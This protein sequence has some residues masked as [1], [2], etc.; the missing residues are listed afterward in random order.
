MLVALGVVLFTVVSASYSGSDPTRIS[1]QVVTGIGFLG[2]GTI[3]RMGA[4]IKGLTSAA[5]IWATAAISMA[6]GRGGPYFIVATVSTILAIIT[7]FYVDKVEKKYR[8]HAEPCLLRV[9]LLNRSILHDL[10]EK[11]NYENIELKSINIVQG[12]PEIEV[13]ME[14]SGMGSTAIQIATQVHGVLGANWATSSTQA[15]P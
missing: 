10:I 5:S 8:P 9:R 11:L 7:L 14:V 3:L 12:E 4:E 2:A 1:A 15:N 6:V 13:S